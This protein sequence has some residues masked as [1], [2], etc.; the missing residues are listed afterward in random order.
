MDNYFIMN[1]IENFRIN[2]NLGALRRKNLSPSPINQFKL[3]FNELSPENDFNAM[4]LSTYNK[5]DGV[6]NRVVL[7]KDIKR[8]GFV[9][10]TNYNSLKS[11][12]IE[13]NNN[14]SICFF[15]PDRQRQVRVN[16]KAYKISN[17]A[18]IQ[19][20]KKR[21][22]KSQ[23]SAWVSDQ[24][25]V[26]LNRKKI[27]SKFLYFSNKFKGK[28]VPKPSYWGGYKVIPETFEFW[29]GRKDRMH[30]RFL[31]QKSHSRWSIKRLNP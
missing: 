28:I 5:L 30:D 29:Q 7:L 25:Q 8:D 19:Y 10:Y 12:Q 23:I 26:V 1:K 24:S 13:S 27:E 4:V 18:S 14:V 15:W 17:Q 20:F 11:R 2:Y 22:R 21:P 9:F 16:G 3:W 31:Y 6:Q